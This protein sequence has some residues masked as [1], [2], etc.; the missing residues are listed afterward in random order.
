MANVSWTIYRLRC[1][2]NLR[3]WQIEGIHVTVTHFKPFWKLSSSHML[4]D[5][6]TLG[7]GYSIQVKRTAL[8]QLRIVHAWRQ[9]GCNCDAT[10]THPMKYAGFIIRLLPIKRKSI[11]WKSIFDDDS[12]SAS[13]GWT[14]FRV[15]TAWQI[16]VSSQ[17]PCHGPRNSLT[18]IASGMKLTSS[19]A[20][21]LIYEFFMCKCCFEDCGGT[22]SLNLN[23]TI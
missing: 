23:L 17:S 21:M 10:I 6:A 15:V 1:G 22:A 11:E 7:W 14:H 13:S 20:Q 2:V 16:E 9:P 18:E 4:L 3:L 5:T 12:K 8:M 19:R